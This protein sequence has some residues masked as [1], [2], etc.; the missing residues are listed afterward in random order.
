MLYMKRS[1]LGFL[2]PGLDQSFELKYLGFFDKGGTQ[3]YVKVA[4]ASWTR[5]KFLRLDDGLV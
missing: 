5:L 4:W 1:G 2:N 3:L